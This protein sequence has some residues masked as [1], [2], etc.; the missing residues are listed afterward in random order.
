MLTLNKNY[1]ALTVL[2]FILETVIAL[3]VH[4]QFIR[5]YLGDVLVVILIYCFVKSFLK[6]PAFPA[7]FGVLLFACGVEVLQYFNFVT[8]LGLE[9]HKVARIVLGSSFDWQD[10]LAYLGGFGLLLFFENRSVLKK[11]LSF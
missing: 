6:V 10:L 9:N 4:D 7:A 3:Y 11:P 8:V 2:L 5:P 1:L